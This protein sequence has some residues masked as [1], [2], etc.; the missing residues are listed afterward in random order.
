MK[1]NDAKKRLVL[2]VL[3]LALP[4]LAS[5]AEAAFPPPQGWYVEANGGYSLASSKSYG[6]PNILRTG[7]GWNVNLGYKVS[8]FFSAEAGYTH[9]FPTRLYNGPKL[10]QDNHFSYD[11]SIK[12]I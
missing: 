6:V 3:L 1:R 7:F 12:G 2:I 10:G 4:L 11:L 9:Y 8:T 5:V